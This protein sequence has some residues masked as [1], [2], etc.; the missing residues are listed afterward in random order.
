MGSHVAATFLY[1]YSIDVFDML[2]ISMSW[3]ILIQYTAVLALSL[4]FFIPWC[5]VC[6][7][8]SMSGWSDTG[9]SILF[10]FNKTSSCMLI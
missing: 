8:C 3:L 10:P 1:V 6:S 9:T 4:L 5:D 7:C 2:G